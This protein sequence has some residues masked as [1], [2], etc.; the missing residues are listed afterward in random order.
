[1]AGNDRRPE[2]GKLNSLM[3]ICTCR[4]SK[5]NNYVVA[6]VI[7]LFLG[8]AL[9]FFS[10]R[11]YVKAFL[12]KGWGFDDILLI[13]GVVGSSIMLYPF[14]ADHHTVSF[15]HIFC[16]RSDRSTLWHWETS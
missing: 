3:L 10:L 5:A 4:G 15:Y 1:M 14:W 7:A 12:T 9:L 2:C 16:M 11:M 6:V 8:L 13:I